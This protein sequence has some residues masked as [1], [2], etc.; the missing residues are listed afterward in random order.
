MV[1]MSVFLKFV[2]ESDQI[3]FLQTLN[4]PPFIRLFAERRAGEE[5]VTR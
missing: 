2:F 3:L 1:L 4:G 5:K